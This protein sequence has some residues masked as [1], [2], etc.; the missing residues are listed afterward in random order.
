MFRQK[1]EPFGNW[2][3]RIFENKESG[4]RFSL[5]PE[6]GATVLELIF[7]G[8]NILDH[9]QSPE[10][11]EVGAWSK[12]AV[13]F[14]FPNR[15]KN[16]QYETDGKKYQFPINDNN[17]QNALHGLGHQ[18][19]F[20]VKHIEL[21]ST[22]AKIICTYQD[23][24]EN[25]SYPFPFVCKI[26]FCIKTDNEFEVELFF[27]NNSQQRIPVGLG[28]HPYFILSEKINDCFLQMP[29]CQMI[30]VDE[31]M[32][33]TGTKYDYS[34][35]KKKKKIEKVVLDNGFK[36]KK[37]NG[38]AAIIVEGDYGTLNYWQEVGHRLWNFVQVFTP[39]NRKSIAIEPMT[40]NID[41]FN[42]R[43]GL[44]LLESGEKI[45]GKFGLRLD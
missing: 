42:N 12:N 17:T 31:Y 35:F 13:L 39:P 23:E 37:E 27:Q 22:E 6:F 32:I 2:E 3:R 7:N 36:L 33:P 16:G 40:C 19:P 8:K 24:G 20:S 9:Y 45:G 26:S 14:P 18:K 15:L 5:V 28:W 43:D 1:I 30:E 4:C 44:I 41:A 29:T 10:E 34:F 21:S 11:L 25:E 38:R